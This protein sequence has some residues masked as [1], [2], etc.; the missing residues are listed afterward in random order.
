MNKIENPKNKKCNPVHLVNLVNPVQ[1]EWHD[2]MNVF[3]FHVHL[4]L[5]GLTR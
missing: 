3:D 5:T 2:K 1:K 4:I